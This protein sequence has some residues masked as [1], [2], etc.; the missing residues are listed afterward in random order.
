MAAF[1]LPTQPA[2]PYYLA[3]PDMKAAIMYVLILNIT[4]IAL[5]FNSKK[6]QQMATEETELFYLI[7]KADSTTPKKPLLVLLHGFGSNEQDLFTLT[8]LVPQNWVVVALRGPIALGNHQYAWYHAQLQQGKITINQPEEEKSRELITKWIKHKT[9][10]WNIDPERIVVAGFSQGGSLAGS[11]ALANP[12]AVTGFAVFSGR[13]VEEIR[14]FIK[15]S[16]NYKNMKAFITHG[17]NDN[18]LP[19]AYAL[20]NKQELDRLGINT[21]YNEDNNGHAIS[22]K[23]INAFVNW[24]NT[25][26]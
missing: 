3:M 5:A 12:D 6:E 2:T 22:P 4:A 7:R 19:A 15:A 11:I 8:G 13:F 16:K 18:M 21:V 25:Y 9:N 24:L 14:P 26:Q 20:N 23:Q 1:V 10:E 17:T